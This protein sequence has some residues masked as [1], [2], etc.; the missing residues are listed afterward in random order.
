[1]NATAAFLGENIAGD[2]AFL[3]N[4]A[5]GGIKYSLALGCLFTDAYTY[6]LPHTEKVVEGT[7]L[8]AEQ[9]EDYY[10]EHDTALDKSTAVLVTTWN[11]E[12]NATTLR[13]ENL[14]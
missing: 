3:H 10:R 14:Y 5:R 12:R 2:A 8:T 13:V 4:A 6:P 7:T 1:M 9:I 11:K